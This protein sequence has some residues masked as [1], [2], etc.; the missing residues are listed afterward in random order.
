M[1]PSYRHLEVISKG[2][3]RDPRTPPLLFVHGAWHAAWC[4]DRGFLDRL[5]GQGF[6]VHAVSLRGHGESDGRDRLRVTRVR[7]YV[8]D[9]NSVVDGLSAPP[10]VVGHSMGGFVVQKLME[11]RPLPGAVLMASVPPN[12]VAALLPKL[13]RK[14]PVGMLLANLTLALKPLVSTTDRVKGLFFSDDVS[15]A[16]LEACAASMGNE[17]FFAYLDMLFADLCQPSAA[18]PILVLGAEADALFSPEATRKVAAAYQTAAVIFPGM[19]HNMMLDTGWE[20]VADAI[21]AWVRV[22]CVRKV[23]IAA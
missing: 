23:R 3:S 22:A 9:V 11:R 13:I 20:Q 17:A 15:A 12:G 4:W 10:V 14:D 2:E 5:A 7:D 21:A 6:E 18:T 8:D 1:L 16:D 19:G